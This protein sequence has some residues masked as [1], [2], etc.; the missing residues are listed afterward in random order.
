MY[1]IMVMIIEFADFAFP[2]WVRCAFT[3]RNNQ[4]GTSLG[5]LR[6]RRNNTL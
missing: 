2:G 5:D 6:G 1:G 4:Y 3:D